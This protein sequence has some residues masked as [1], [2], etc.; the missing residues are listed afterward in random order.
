MA[1][2][3]HVAGIIVHAP[4]A[5]MAEVRRAIASIAGTEVHAEGNG[6]L[7]VTVEATSAND[8]ADRVVAVGCLDGVLSA[9]PVYHHAE[10]PEDMSC[11]PVAT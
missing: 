10:S 11:S 6:K 9:A 1:A 2:E 8:L 7:V 5:R 4:P 3:L